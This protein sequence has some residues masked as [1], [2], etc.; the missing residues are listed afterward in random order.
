MEGAEGVLAKNGF[1]ADGTI[2]WSWN[3][4]YKLAWSN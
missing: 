4:L 3:I 1:I 2:G